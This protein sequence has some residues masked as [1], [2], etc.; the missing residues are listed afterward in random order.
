[1]EK[2]S[3]LQPG[4]REHCQGAYSREVLEARDDLQF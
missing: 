2:V 4:N 1:M 3:N